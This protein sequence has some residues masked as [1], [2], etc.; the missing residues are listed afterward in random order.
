MNKEDLKVINKIRK[1][2]QGMKVILSIFIETGKLTI[3]EP[4]ECLTENE[5][6]TLFNKVLE[7][8]ALNRPAH[9]S[10]NFDKLEV[11]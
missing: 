9:S 10:I 11:H 4:L 3:T 1:S 8:A 2:P 7:M 5:I 6:L